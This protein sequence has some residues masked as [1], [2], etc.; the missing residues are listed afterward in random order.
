MASDAAAEG[1]QEDE[2][3]GADPQLQEFGVT[4]VDAEEVEQHIIQRVNF[5]AGV[6]ANLLVL[7]AEID[8][9][10]CESSACWCAVHDMIVDCF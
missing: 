7:D 6:S 9:Y 2:A 1:T 8:V 10:L 4:A 3:A 5:V